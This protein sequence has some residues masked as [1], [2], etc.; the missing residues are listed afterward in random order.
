VP[1]SGSYADYR[2]QLL[3]WVECAERLRVYC[4]EVEVPESGNALVVDL[5]RRLSALADQVDKGF[6]ANSELSIDPDGTPHL[7][8]QRA[9]PPPS[10]L[11]AFREAVHARMPERHL[12]DVLKHVHHWVPFTRHFGP[13]SGS[14]PKLSDSVR[15]YLFTVFLKSTEFLPDF[16]TKTKPQP[17]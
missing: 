10:D 3:P 7:K 16:S 1:G 9:K 17:A 12:L 8:L 5:R 6:P 15:R 13:P 4:A 2:A 14:D 11:N